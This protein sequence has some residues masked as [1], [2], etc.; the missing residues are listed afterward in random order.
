MSSIAF[1]Q[2]N[3]KITHYVADG[4]M[5]HFVTSSVIQT[6]EIQLSVKLNAHAEDKRTRC[7]IH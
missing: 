2:P 1:N 7:L 4:M 3:I 5:G 6:N